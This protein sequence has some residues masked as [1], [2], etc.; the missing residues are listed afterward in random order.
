MK[1]ILSM[2]FAVTFVV[3][4]CVANEAA[5]RSGLKELLGVQIES[6]FYAGKNGCLHGGLGIIAPL[7]ANQNIGMVGHFVREEIDGEMFPCRGAEFIQ[8]FGHGFE[9]EPLSFGYLPVEK[10]NAWSVGLSGARRFTL[11]EHASITPFFGP[12]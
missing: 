9:L 7:N 2:G 5:S 4:L 12:A 10:Q 3:N 11:N 8:D 6:D 1:P